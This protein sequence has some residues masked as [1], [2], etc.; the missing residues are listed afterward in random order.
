[1][2]PLLSPHR[3][4]M[5][6]H[7]ARRAPRGAASPLTPRPRAPRVLLLAAALLAWRAQPAAAA[8]VELLYPQL[9]AAQQ[10]EPLRN[11]R[12]LVREYSTLVRREG[13]KYL[14]V[15]LGTEHGHVWSGAQAQSF[16]IASV[17][18]VTAK[19]AE[20]QAELLGYARAFFE[21]W[22]QM[23]ERTSWS[24]LSCADG[25]AAASCGSAGAAWAGRHPCLPHRGWDRELLQPVQTGS[26]ADADA[27][28]ILA[29]VLLVVRFEE[30]GAAPWWEEMGQW[31]F[32]SCRA[33]VELDTEPS[34]D[35]TE[36]VVRLGSCEGGWS[37]LSPASHSP[38][39]YRVF[40]AYMRDYAAVF[41]PPPHAAGARHARA[42]AD[43]S[44]YGDKWAQLVRSSYRVLSA[45][46]CRE[47]GLVVNWF[48]PAAS[49]LDGE[50]TAA[51]LPCRG[52]AP[53]AEYGKEAARF[54][55]GLFLDYVWFG[56]ARGAEAEDDP[57]RL[58]WPLVD[59]VVGRVR[60]MKAGCAS[61]ACDAALN[62]SSGCLVKSVYPRWTEEGLMLAPLAA[63]LMVPVS[64]YATSRTAQQSALSTLA[65]LVQQLDYAS[66][67]EGADAAGF[68][69]ATL[70][71]LAMSRADFALPN[72]FR[73]RRRGPSGA[74]LLPPR[75][76][77]P[78]PHPPAPP[79]PR[80]PPPSP[81]PPPP[82]PPSPGRCGWERMRE[83]SLIGAR[84]A[85][86]AAHFPSREARGD[87]AACEALCDAIEE[88]AG[89]TFDRGEAGGQC[90]LVSSL[91]VPISVERAMVS[92]L[93]RTH[94]VGRSCVSR[95]KSSRGDSDSFQCVE[96]CD[97]SEAAD[98]CK[99]CACRGCG[100][101]MPEPPPAPPAPP[102]P[103]PP[104]RPARPPLQPP[105]PAPPPA[106]KLGVRTEIS[107]YQG[108]VFEM[109][110]HVRH[111]SEGVT[112]FLDFGPTKLHKVGH[113]S[114]AFSVPSDDAAVLAFQLVT[115][116]PDGTAYFEVT[117]HVPFLFINED[118][119]GLLYPVVTCSGT[120]SALSPSPPPSIPSPSPPPSPPRPPPPP[121]P[122]P[123][124]PPPSP[125][126][127]PKP[128]SPLPPPPRPPPHP[129]PS[130]P[131]VPES[132]PLGTSFAVSPLAKKHLQAKIF[133]Q[134]WVEG[135]VLRLDFDAPLLGRVDQ[136]N[137][138][139]LLPRADAETALRFELWERAREPFF[140]F[141]LLTESEEYRPPA[142]QVTC[143]AFLPRPPP[144]R[145]PPLPPPPRPPYPP[146]PPLRPSA[147]SAE[148]CD[149][150]AATHGGWARRTPFAGGHVC[151]ESERG[152]GGCHAAASLPEAA[153]LCDGAGAR[154]CTAAELRA[155]AAAASGCHFDRARVWSAT[156]CAGGAQL[157]LA[158]AAA[159]A[160]EFGAA[161]AA[162]EAEEALVEA[163]GGG[164]G[165][166]VV[167]GLRRLAAY[168][169]RTLASNA[170]GRAASR[171]FAGPFAVGMLHAH[172][173][174]RPEAEPTSSRSV[175]LRWAAI[176]GQCHAG[177]DVRWRVACR[178]GGGAWEELAGGVAGPAWVAPVEC[179]AGCA[180]RVAPRLAG[181]AQWS[182]A[183]APVSTPPLA[184]AAGGAA[185]VALRLD[186]TPAQLF[187]SRR[188]PQLQA[189]LSAAL[190]LP[191]ARLRVAEAVPLHEAWE[192][193]LDVLPADGAPPVQAD[194]VAAL[195]GASLG[196]PEG[197]GLR[198]GAITRLI[199]ATHGAWLMPPPPSAAAPEA[200]APPA[201]PAAP[202]LG[203][204]ASGGA[205][206]ASG[207][208]VEL[209]LVAGAC[210]LL[211]FGGAFAALHKLRSRAGGQ[212]AAVRTDL[213]T[214]DAEAE[215]AE[216]QPRLHSD[217]NLSALLQSLD[218]IK[219][220]GEAH[221][222]QSPRQAGRP[223][224][225]A[226]EQDLF[227]F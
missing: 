16:L 164:G 205:L 23:C 146:M 118:N 169:V 63:A 61:V 122:P 168:R 66:V 190:G 19:S 141:Y 179:A 114:A 15:A 111:F 186:A 121:P 219:A 53:A 156:P 200:A 120:F 3:S 71:S 185:R 133:V 171:G 52:A 144:P 37:C 173:R 138:A 96:W 202:P 17:A 58:L 29:M 51:A 115:P 18:A 40:Q 69:W 162:G 13:G 223:T 60:A 81:A 191:A 210:T 76:P 97:A 136:G 33:F 193:V 158:G 68:R 93:C 50:G 92:G 2:A 49:G 9:P 46:H 142:P 80:A 217:H 225:S 110:L 196:R 161:A 116:N 89:Y 20:E 174:G 64:T 54:S 207:A 73:L 182:E 56:A 99:W 84:R 199:N 178:R 222:P 74:W 153:A 104:P 147:A 39:H 14:R 155:D 79:V 70:A 154:L 77:R 166:V 221:E 44:A 224:D 209:A 204:A 112:L 28:A 103:P 88:C 106:C 125:P 38:A 6:P 59:H 98:H 180:F 213:A 31:A 26:A 176:A 135:A 1:M 85:P 148:G 160:A 87:A 43:L 100:W 129:P 8:A 72:A 11:V 55:W 172:L 150:L 131:P 137:R 78:P 132:C 65:A 30:A 83:S 226:D 57:K 188:L 109:A 167:A 212:Y 211:C 22:R 113:S 119:V 21:G 25:E 102:P 36:R 128:R 42:P 163:R 145:R 75:P 151:A 152:L 130:P 35:G 198:A 48:V 124:P 194:G 195:L 187:L 82:H 107:Y 45:A 177:G 175:R 91:F 214:A 206:P 95:K 126:S 47:T 170:A 157:A 123:H 139:S 4:A 220:L 192:V 90:F 134:H 86:L 7:H 10:M 165:E 105:L 24:S 5:P 208:P 201:P 215:L 41:A 184:A 181:W 108:D 218:S 203:R 140:D 189:E 27:D 149:A 197:E 12:L 67:G 127:L 101:C 143:H 216:A 183:S 227:S 94:H 62:L 32:D 159:A 117:A 34:G